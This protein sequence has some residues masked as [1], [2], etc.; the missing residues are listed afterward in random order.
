MYNLSLEN[1][2]SNKLDTFWSKKFVAM[3]KPYH[4]GFADRTSK[5]CDYTKRGDTSF[6]WGNV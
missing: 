1:N 3:S 6:F 5:K 4:L 2:N